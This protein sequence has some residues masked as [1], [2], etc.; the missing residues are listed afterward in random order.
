MMPSVCCRH[1]HSVMSEGSVYTARD[2]VALVA[3]GSGGIGAAVVE[4]FARAGC[5]VVFTY[6]KNRTRAEAICASL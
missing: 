2:G 1:F 5:P 4:A 3:G 6:H